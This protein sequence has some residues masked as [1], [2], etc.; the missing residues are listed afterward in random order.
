[1][2]TPCPSGDT[3]H[4][5]LHLRRSFQELIY[6]GIMQ[7]VVLVFAS[8]FIQVCAKLWDYWHPNSC[9]DALLWIATVLFP[10]HQM[11]LRVDETLDDHSG[12]ATCEDLWNA[13][14]SSMVI[15][16][17]FTCSIALFAIFKYER[18]FAD[19]LESTRPFWKFW[20]V[21]GLLSVNYL[22]TIVLRFC[23]V[24]S[25]RRCILIKFFLLCVESL[26][27][28]GVNVFAYRTPEVSLPR[29]CIGGR[30]RWLASLRRIPEVNLARE[31]SIMNFVQ[32]HRGDVPKR[33]D[34][35]STP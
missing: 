35:C 10:H 17:F 32:F 34:S 21:K 6:A 15:A 26:V 33:M 4:R 24:G 12:A 28:A 22:Q 5:T 13:V 25:H 20:G 9:H 8:N 7:Y 16:N 27:L 29:A 14:A 18:A 11:S 2:G 31:F 3:W 1:M 23:W 30:R 19:L